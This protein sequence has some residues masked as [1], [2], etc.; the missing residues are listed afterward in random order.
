M[1]L[2]AQCRVYVAFG[3]GPLAASPTW[4]E[5]TAYVRSVR[6]SRGRS[7]ELE[8]F[9][10]GTATI[11]LS[12]RDRRF[13][14][15]H[16][17]GPYYPDVL[18]RR[19]VKVEAVHSGVTYPVFRGLVQSW[20][21]AYPVDGRDATATLQCADLFSLLAT[22]D[23]PES[24]HEL[25]ARSLG[26][27]SL[28]ALDGDTMVDTVGGN[29]G[30]Y[31]GSREEV[32]PIGSGPGAS[33]L[34]SAVGAAT[35]STLGRAPFA[36]T[37]TTCT[38]SALVYPRSGSASIFFVDFQT[39]SGAWWILGSSVGTQ[40]YL[41]VAANVLAFSGQPIL[42][43]SLH[44]VA[45]T[46]DGTTLRLYI[47]G[48]EAGSNTNASVSGSQTTTGVE[49]GKALANSDND[50]RQSQVAVWGSSVLT[51]TQLGTL[52]GAA[53][54]GWGS[55]PASTRIQRILDVLGVPSAL[56]SIQASS[57]SLGPF[58]GGLDALSY[59]QSCARS[60]QGRLYV[61]RAGVLTFEAKTDDMGATSAATFADDA[62]VNSVRYT[63]FQLELDDRLVYN[64]VTVTG[65]GDAAFTAQNATSI[66]VYSRRALQVDTELP[67][68][69]ACRDVAEVILARYAA[70]RTRG[71]AW[72]MH[73]E[74]TLN[75]STTRAWATVLA[76]ELGEV[77]TV[78]RT[79]PVG[80]PIAKTVQVTSIE[81][82]VDLP[83]GRWDVT[84]T[85]APVDTSSAFRWGTSTW[86]GADEWNSSL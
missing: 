59:L 42:D 15:D 73:P 27:T 26:V 80:S 85:G 7:N 13:D 9:N 39:T 25:Y 72:T 28:W 19:Q 10:A 23:L 2:S 12:N 76:R 64:D 66:A 74:R 29:N 82:N 75:G 33:R 24:A 37:S 34:V 83:A 70:P 79:P 47:D 1:A 61:S 8:E 48:V 44:H 40:G 55:D 57:S 41:S 14:P 63:G 62:T 53:L 86:G 21:Q 5:V 54:T 58:E 3:D 16:A 30:F 11:V 78:K 38:V 67:S 31:G 4:T 43:D 46:R 69:G 56:Y 68:A 52:A 32:D 65:V 22:W 51:A 17:A 81:H 36:N 60:D 50:F 18:P 71:R 45:A 6:T 77:V 35:D 20:V 84:F 49:I